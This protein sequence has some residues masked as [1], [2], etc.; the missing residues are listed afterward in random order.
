MLID[1]IL[2]LIPYL[3]ILDIRFHETVVPDNSP[4]NTKQKRK[5]L[6]NLHK[7]HLLSCSTR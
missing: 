1:F 3:N 2:Y 5:Y 7:F 6:R 4:M